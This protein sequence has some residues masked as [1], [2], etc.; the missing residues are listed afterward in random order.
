MRKPQRRQRGGRG[1]GSP[2]FQRWAG[3]W[4]SQAQREAWPKGRGA[5]V[6]FM[7][8]GTW[9]SILCIHNRSSSVHFSLPS[10]P[11]IVFSVYLTTSQ[12]T[13]GICFSLGLSQN[14]DLFLISALSPSGSV[15]LISPYA[16]GSPAQ[17]GSSTPSVNSSGASSSHSLSA[18]YSLT[19]RQY[20]TR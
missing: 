4:E 2:L 20:F 12:Q 7:P 15:L 6:P 11:P 18:F 5:L 1:G 16:E 19:F 13:A 10:K 14:P 8:L 9:P 3:R 17:A